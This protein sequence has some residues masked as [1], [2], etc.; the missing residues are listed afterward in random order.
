MCVDTGVAKSL[1]RRVAT[2]FTGLLCWAVA[3]AAQVCAVARAT[4]PHQR[5]YITAPGAQCTRQVVS[6]QK[7]A[8]A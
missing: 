1:Q 8:Q 5:L 2:V 6:G 4:H 3:W 7:L